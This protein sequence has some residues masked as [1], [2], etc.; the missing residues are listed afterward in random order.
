MKPYGRQTCNHNHRDYH[1][2]KG[3]VN[4]WEAE[5]ND[6]SKKRE[7]RKARME[8]RREVPDSI[9]SGRRSGKTKTTTILTLEE[10][11]NKFPEKSGF[12][13]QIEKI[14]KEIMDETI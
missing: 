10:L 9:L 1:P 6:I 7:R 3:W 14:Q 11:K 5:I 12:R 4:W 2:P 8:L 13:A